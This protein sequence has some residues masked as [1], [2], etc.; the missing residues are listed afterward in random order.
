MEEEDNIVREGFG[1]LAN[2]AKSEGPRPITNGSGFR[3]QVQK[4]ASLL[5]AAQQEAAK[6]LLAEVHAWNPTPPVVLAAKLAYPELG[7]VIDRA[8]QSITSLKWY[9]EG[10]AL[11]DVDWIGNEKYGWC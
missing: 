3:K 11:E 7:A 4:I 10:S 2:V 6:S 5:F 1:D 8:S 9:G